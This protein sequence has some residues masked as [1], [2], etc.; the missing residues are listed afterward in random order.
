[1][2]PSFSQRY[3]Y[4]PLPKPMRLEELSSDLRVEIWNEVR[5]FLLGKRDGLIIGPRHFFTEQAKRF[6]ERVIGRYTERPSDTISTEYKEALITFKN[7]MLSDKFNRV[8]D[9]IEIM[10]ND[11]DVTED[12]VKGMNT[13]F[14]Q[15]AAAYR[16]DTSQRPYCF[17]PQASKEQGE[18]TQEAI[19]IIH[20]SKFGGA[21]AHL[22]QATEHINAQQYADS[23]ADSIHA[24]ESVARVIDPKASKTLA[25]ALKAAFINLY[26]YTSNEQGIRHALLD[27]NSPGVGLDEAMFMFGAC[28]SFAA[29]LAEKHRQDKG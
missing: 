10:V 26:G 12:F 29:Y 5:E 2:S 11:K 18:A 3:G 22:R 7:S 8:L 23:I 14:E 17:V 25:P 16:L 15:C 27:Q 19:K 24:V 9:L 21:A 1:M 4:E 28:A 6:I 13:S 20:E